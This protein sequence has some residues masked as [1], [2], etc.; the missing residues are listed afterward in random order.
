M[1]EKIEHSGVVEHIEGNKVGVRITQSS[2]CSTCE[3]KKL[4]EKSESQKKIIECNS[5]GIKYRIGEQVMVY[6]SMAMRRDAAIIAFVVPLAI[7]IIWL[8]IAIGIIHL[9]ELI[10]IGCMIGILAIY[11]IILYFI[12]GL[13]S[14]KFEFRIEKNV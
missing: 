10:A 11:Y 7:I 9:N 1:N 14:K 6:G 3:A 2:V 13:I 4:C 5:N 12:N 8:F